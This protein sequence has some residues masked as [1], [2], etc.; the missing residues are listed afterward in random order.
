MKAIISQFVLK[1]RSGVEIVSTEGRLVSN[2]KVLR[3]PSLK[4]DV[5]K[6]QLFYQFDKVITM[7]RCFIIQGHCDIP[8]GGFQF[9]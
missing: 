9:H 6:R 8:H 4:L 1:E 5:Y 3:V 2:D 7:F